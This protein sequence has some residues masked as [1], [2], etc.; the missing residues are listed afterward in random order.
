M[1]NSL[2]HKLGFSENPYDTKPLNVLESDVNLLMGRE[3]EQVEFLT[4][5]ESSTDGVF[6][7]SG[8]P[9]VGKTSFLNI[10]QYLIEN[11]QGYG[12]K[13]LAARTLCP[14]QPS[15]EPKHIAIR[16]LQSFTKSIQQFCE[17]NGKKLPKQ[18]EKVIN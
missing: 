11:G 17:L 4:S 15:D 8:V 6:V 13:F 3:S 16:S 2:W 5:I 18:V 14:I 1:S 10:Q 12:D 9:G 7:I